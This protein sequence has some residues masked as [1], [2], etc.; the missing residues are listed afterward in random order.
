MK[1]ELY[2]IFSAT[3]IVFLAIILLLN[4][5]GSAILQTTNAGQAIESSSPSI[6]QEVS[7]FMWHYRGLDL[8]AQAFV[9][10]AA[11]ACCI[12]MLRD[13]GEKE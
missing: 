12:S 8:V 9:L 10:F 1:R 2:T 6:G 3:L 7:S 11:A 13:E 4:I 5:S